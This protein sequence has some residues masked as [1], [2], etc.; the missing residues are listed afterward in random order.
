MGMLVV[1]DAHQLKDHV[2]MEATHHP[3]PLSLTREPDQAVM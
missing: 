2:N 3:L 1:K